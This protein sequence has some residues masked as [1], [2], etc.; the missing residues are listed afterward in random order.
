MPPSGYKSLQRL[1]HEVVLVKQGTLVLN[2]L[3]L[4]IEE[5]RVSFRTKTKSLSSE[6]LTPGTS[7]KRSDMDSGSCA[8]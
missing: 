1:R 8:A 4:G 5:E 7:D 2:V 3:G 6:F